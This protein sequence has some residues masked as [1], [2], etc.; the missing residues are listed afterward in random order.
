MGDQLAPSQQPRSMQWP[1]PWSVSSAPCLWVPCHVQSVILLL[2][3]KSCAPHYSRAA[4]LTPITLVAEVDH[5][6][7]VLTRSIW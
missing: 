6:N 1:K 3:R 5:P 2:E 7:V 4:A